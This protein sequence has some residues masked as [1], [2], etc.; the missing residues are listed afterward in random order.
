M[1][2]KEPASYQDDIN[3]DETALDVEWLNQPRLMAKY[4]VILATAARDV[5]YSKEN[6]DVVRA[7]LELEVRD[8][9]EAFGV[10]KGTRVTEALVTAIVLGC[11]KY[12]KASREYIDAKYEH[13]IALGIVRAFDQ[14]KS[15]LENLVRLHGQSYF[16]GPTIP[17]DLAEQ[18][19]AF[20]ESV[21]QKMK[22]RRRL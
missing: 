9:P 7:D 17:R 20:D 1:S 3:I 13:N 22:F 19:K 4:A 14:R 15:S 16:A 8:K 18:R 21:Q 5:D 11:D 10:E 6:L 2:E 12:K